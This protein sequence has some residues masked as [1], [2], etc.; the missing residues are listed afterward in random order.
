[1][2]TEPTLI[3]PLRVSR[4]RNQGSSIVIKA[5]LILIVVINQSCYHYRVSS[6][7]FDPGTSYQKKTVHSFFW[8]LAQKRTNGIDVVTENCDK[9]NVNKIDEVRVTTNLGYSLINVI[10]LGIWS[11]IQVEWKCAKPAPREG[12]TR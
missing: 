5:I 4:N 7:N 9:I 2:N 10:T 12:S 3:K 1:M 11:P 6:A 8:G